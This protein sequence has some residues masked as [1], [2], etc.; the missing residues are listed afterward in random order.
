MR[1]QSVVIYTTKICP[2]CVRAKALFAR[3]G[4]AYRE[5]DVSNDDAT[6]MW[7]VQTSGQRTVP[8]I[9]INDKPVGGFDEVAA[10]D[11]KGELDRLLAG[12]SSGAPAQS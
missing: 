12:S 10:L 3:K 8:Q 4:V 11:R 1:V 2:Y 5:I 6:R 9:F 7:L